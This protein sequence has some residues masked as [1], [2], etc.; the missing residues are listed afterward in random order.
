MRY[1]QTIFPKDSHGDYVNAITEASCV[2]PVY[3][4]KKRGIMN[5]G[6]DG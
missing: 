5:D 3:F 1:D 6:A 4:E 2:P